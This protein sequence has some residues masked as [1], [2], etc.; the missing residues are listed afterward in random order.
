MKAKQLGL[1]LVATLTVV[2][3]QAFA[4]TDDYAYQANLSGPKQALQ[5]VELPIDI[6]LAVTRADLG[7]VAVFDATGKQLPSWVRKVPIQISQKQIELPFYV[8]STYLQRHSKTLTI[9]EQNQRQDQLSESTT[10]ETIPINRTRQD[11]IIELP[12]K[13]DGMEI[14]S[15]ALLWAHQPADQLLQLRVEVG[16]DLDNWRTIHRSKSLTNQNS[17]K[18]EWRSIDGIPKGQKYLRLVSLKSI[19]SFELQKVVGTYNKK[20]TERKLW[21]RLEAPQTVSKQKGFLAF[22]MP[23]A[24]KPHEL[25]LIPGES[26][27]L[28]RGNLFA[29]KNDFDHKRLI[30]TDLQQHNITGSDIK[31]SQP[32]EIPRE[33]Y[34]HWWFEPK[35]ALPTPPVV[36]ISFPVYEVLFLGTDNGPFTLAWGNYESTAP[37]N[38]LIGILNSDQQNQQTQ[39]RLV[40]L[41]AVKIAGG[42][43][44][45][46]SEAKLPWLK[47]LLWL[48]LIVAVA[49]TGKMAIILYR[50]MNA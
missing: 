4:A 35:Q 38:A 23:S 1:L 20:M 11:Y 24:V 46:S 47:W 37:A 19:R 41:S 42:E 28:I 7:D 22:D 8:F 13:E 30:R 32:V 31:P 27:T 44:R 40:Q 16:S 34:V 14:E 2:F 9:R 21:H 33:N 17:D 5:R 50:D 15:I 43:S 3:N 6:L 12:D 25:R 49:G 36:E 45:L 10:T 26:Q 18:K 29:S 39:V 48:L